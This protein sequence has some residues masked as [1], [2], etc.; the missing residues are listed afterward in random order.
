MSGQAEQGP[1][2]E[3]HGDGARGG[4][5]LDDGDEE[6]PEGQHAPH[7]HPVDQGDQQHGG[8]QVERAVEEEGGGHVQQ[9]GG[10]D[11]LVQQRID[12]FSAIVPKF[13]EGEILTS[14]S[15]GN[16]RE[17]TRKFGI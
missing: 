17:R 15:G 2:A 5:S 7:A 6:V 3:H 13:G 8:G 1:G 14:S 4:G 11:G 9:L 10:R 16:L 12:Q